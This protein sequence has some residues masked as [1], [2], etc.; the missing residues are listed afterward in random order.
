MF[1]KLI[2]AFFL[3]FTVNAYTVKDLNRVEFG[4]NYKMYLGNAFYVPNF[5]EIDN[6]IPV[7]YCTYNQSKRKVECKFAKEVDMKI[8]YT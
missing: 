3:L 7:D 8:S 4:K 6:N 1:N 2:I 5:G